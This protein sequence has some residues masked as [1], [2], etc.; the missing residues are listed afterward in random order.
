MPTG[1]F[2]RK[3]IIKKGDKYNLLTA[4]CLD[5]KDDKSNQFWLFKCNC[6]NKKIINISSVRTGNT[7][8]CGCLLKASGIRNGK[9]RKKHGMIKTPTYRTWQHM[10]SRCYDKNDIDYKYYNSKNRNIIVCERWKNNFINF[11]E[12]MGKRP[13]NRTIDRIDN[14]GNY[15]PTNCRWATAKEQANNRSFMEYKN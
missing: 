12:D 13:I 6:G 14:N 2:K 3:S 4:I 10:K 5:H 1:I 11:F 15:E 7:K 8:S 9:N